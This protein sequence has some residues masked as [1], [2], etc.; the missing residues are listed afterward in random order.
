MALDGFDLNHLPDAF[1]D[2]P[3]PTYA[4]LC[5]QAPVHP[6]PGGGVLVCRHADVNA[7]YR[8]PKRFSSD[9]K[10]QF[11]PVFGADSLIY[12]HH[13]TSLVFNDPPLHTRVR[14][15]IGNTLSRRVVAGLQLELQHLVNQ[16]I[17]QLPTDQ[18][19]D[20]I[21]RFAAA[22]PVEVIGNLLGIPIDERGPLRRWSLA[23]LSVLEPSPSSAMLR[24]GE[25][26]VVEFLS[27]LQE[28]AHTKAEHPSLQGN[29][30][31]RL[32]HWRDQD[33]PLTPQELYHQCIFL[34]NA[35]HETTT[36]LIGNGI[37][38]LADHPQQLE[39][40]LQDP[41]CHDSAIEEILRYESPNQLGNRTTTC[42]LDLGGVT[43]PAETVITLCIGAANRDPEVFTVPQHFDVTRTPNPHLGFG[44]GIHTCAGLSVARLEGRVALTSLFGQFPGLRVVQASRAKRAR[45][46]G[47]SELT[48]LLQ[49]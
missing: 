20:L 14:K 37:C 4:E 10:I 18:P 11:A 6:L 38:L 32:L 25:A 34:L 9:K 39:R 2:N 30:M 12:Q 24:Q 15:A 7:V 42:T 36:N 45:F 41:A 49:G 43:I 5:R 46:R 22:I 31:Q 17:E 33:G 28:F 44:A 40:F 26:A 29:L 19:V 48:V 23:I 27:Y 47:F 16:L 3:Y 8:D 13:T 1:F 21:A 35:G